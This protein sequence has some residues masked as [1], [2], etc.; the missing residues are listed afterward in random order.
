[1]KEENEHVLVILGL[2][3]HLYV[4]LAKTVVSR[5]NVHMH[6]GAMYSRIIKGLSG[7]PKMCKSIPESAIS[8]DMSPETIK[9]L[10]LNHEGHYTDPFDSVVYQMMCS[11]SHY[12]HGDL[13]QLHQ[14]CRAGGA[15][16]R[17]CK[18]EYADM[19]VEICQRWPR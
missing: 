10:I 4:R 14:I 19:L 8:V 7:Y 5:L 16:W 6:I 18:I 11:V 13:E 1:M 15:R 9:E 12:S 3:E 2:E 17:K